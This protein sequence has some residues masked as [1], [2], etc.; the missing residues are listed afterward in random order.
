MLFEATAG[1]GKNIAAYKG[2]YPEATPVSLYLESALYCF[3]DELDSGIYEYL[4]GKC[5]G[6]AGNR[7]AIYFPQCAK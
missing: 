2:V 6:H 5:L 3:R 1:I 7:A 4:L